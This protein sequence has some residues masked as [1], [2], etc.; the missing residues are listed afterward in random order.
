VEAISTFWKVQIKA[1]YPTGMMIGLM[2]R[3][4]A[5]VAYAFVIC[6]AQLGTSQGVK[7]IQ[8]ETAR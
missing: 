5:P 6:C 1:A 8:R 2:D 3:V 7:W 4:S